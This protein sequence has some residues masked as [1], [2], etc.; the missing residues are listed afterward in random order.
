MSGRTIGQGEAI[1]LVRSKQQADGTWLLE[2]THK[3]AIHF[4]MDAGDGQPS[5]WNTLRA[6][7]VLRWSESAPPQRVD[8]PRPTPR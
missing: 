7:R 2:N 3:G 4:Q 8:G 1:E 5:R 6:L